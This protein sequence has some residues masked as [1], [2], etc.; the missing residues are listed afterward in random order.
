M[1]GI[2]AIGPDYIVPAHCMGLDTATLFAK[3]CRSIY[4]HTAAE[5][6]IFATY[7]MG[8]QSYAGFPMR[9]FGNGDSWDRD[10]HNPQFLILFLHAVEES[11][12]GNAEHFGGL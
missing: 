1:A 5:R 9:S 3:R 12:S 8:S 4:P 6:Y 7:V 11:G 2:K 10:I